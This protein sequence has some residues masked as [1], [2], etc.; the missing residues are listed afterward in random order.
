MSDTVNHPAHYNTHAMSDVDTRER[1]DLDI[2]LDQEPNCEIFQNCTQ[3]ANWVA[4]LSACRH[5]F[6]ACTQHH[7][8]I[9]RASQNPNA[10][11]AWVHTSCRTGGSHITW[12][13]L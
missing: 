2:N 12:R 10:A 6:L 9:V 3:T 1:V 5:T 4:T 7:D 8:V 11:N 13:P